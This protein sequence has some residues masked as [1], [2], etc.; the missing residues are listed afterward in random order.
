MGVPTYL[1]IANANDIRQIEISV[2]HALL[3]LADGT[4]AAH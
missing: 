3:L 4:G 2:F 1:S